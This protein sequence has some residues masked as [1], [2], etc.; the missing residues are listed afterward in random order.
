MMRWKTILV[1]VALSVIAQPVFSQFTV[2]ADTKSILIGQPIEITLFLESDTA[3]QAVW[4]SF[5]KGDLLGE[6]AEVLNI[7]KLDTQIK[8]SSRLIQQSLSITSFDSGVWAIPPF[9]AFL[10]GDSVLTEAFVF[11][12]NT[13]KVDTTESLKPIKDPVEFPM[14]FEEWVKEYWW[15]AALIVWAIVIGFLIIRQLKKKPTPIQTKMVEPYIAPVIW[16]EDELDK[17]EGQSL[18]QQGLYKQYHV[19]WSE[20]VREFLEKQYSIPAPESTTDEIKILIHRIDLPEDLK[21]KLIEALKI[22]D[23]VKFART[24][25]LADENEYCLRTAR[26]IVTKVREQ[27]ALKQTKTEQS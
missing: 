21:R 8:S 1:W 16:L 14:T 26:E 9:K 13:V 17:I 11:S 10:N 18:W 25:P 6:K 12:V 27:E 22:S 23:L 19:A 24:T 3:D 15:V 20:T 7:Q 2:E 4:P 5:N